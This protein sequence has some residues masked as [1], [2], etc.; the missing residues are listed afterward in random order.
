MRRFG[1]ESIRLMDGTRIDVHMANNKGRGDN[2]VTLTRV[3]QSSVR[4]MYT[5]QYE[6]VIAQTQTSGWAGHWN[7][8]KRVRQDL[9]VD[10]HL[11]D[12]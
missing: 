6:E 1:V 4:P 2:N 5:R 12:L 3:W 8:S 11:C 10:R 7:F 9:G